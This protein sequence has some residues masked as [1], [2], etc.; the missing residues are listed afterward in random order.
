MIE[1]YDGET[2]TVAGHTFDWHADPDVDV[3]VRE[4]SSILDEV[5]RDTDLA[6]R[7]RQETEAHG[8]D[9]EE[10]IIRHPDDWEAFDARVFNLQEKVAEEAARASKTLRDRYDWAP[11]TVSEFTD[12]EL[13]DS[14]AIEVYHDP[15]VD[16]DVDIEQAER[17]PEATD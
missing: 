8:G 4:I 7:I 3:R 1:T 2:V 12:A 9:P 10:A 16:A 5:G 17:R 11:S 6:D 13:I 14:L 15:T